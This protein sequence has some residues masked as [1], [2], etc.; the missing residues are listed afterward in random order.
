MLQ[1]KQVENVNINCNI[2]DTRLP[3][4]HENDNKRYM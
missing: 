3:L 1:I 2:E 4:Q